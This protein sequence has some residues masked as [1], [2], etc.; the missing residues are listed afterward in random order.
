MVN[1][2]S[3]NIEKSE[4]IKLLVLSKKRKY[5]LG[6]YQN[7]TEEEKNKKQEYDREQYKNLSDTEK[8]RKVECRK[9]II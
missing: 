9:K 4:E 6:R 3:L 8:H 2:H 7:L 5:A 1:V